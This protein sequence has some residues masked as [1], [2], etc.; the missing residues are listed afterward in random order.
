MNRLKQRLTHAPCGLIQ[1]QQR[2]RASVVVPTTARH[3]SVV[4][5]P[6]AAAQHP[7]Q[8]PGLGADLVQVHVVA[9]ALDAHQHDVVARTVRTAPHRHQV[10]GGLFAIAHDRRTSSQA[11]AGAFGGKAAVLERDGFRFDMGPTIVTIPSVLRRIFTDAGRR[12]EDY[13]DMVRLDPQWRCFLHTCFLS[14]KNWG[15]DPT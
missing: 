7:V 3:E 13:L 9:V 2:L 8:A 1:H 10:A 12:M 15:K 14:W 11:P 6:D 5:S 4:F